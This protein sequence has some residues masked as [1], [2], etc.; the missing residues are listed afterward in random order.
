MGVLIIVAYF[1]IT[2]TLSSSERKWVSALGFILAIPCLLFILVRLIMFLWEELFVIAI[3]LLIMFVGGYIQIRRKYSTD[4]I[5][6]VVSVF[7]RL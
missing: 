3:S 6:E 1:I 4:T 7:V 5:L 2:C